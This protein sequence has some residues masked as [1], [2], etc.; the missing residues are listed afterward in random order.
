VLSC[1]LKLIVE[2]DEDAVRTKI[3]FVLIEYLQ[4]VEICDNTDDDS[5]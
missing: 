4:P 1:S 5:D 2:R 3:H